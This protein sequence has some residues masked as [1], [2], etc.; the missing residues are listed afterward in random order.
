MSSLSGIHLPIKTAQSTVPR[1]SLNGKRATTE[2]KGQAK[3]P[4]KK[5]LTLH[6]RSICL[7]I[8]SISRAEV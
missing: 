8:V 5:N 6:L 3:E 1:I 2:D 4:K 7:R